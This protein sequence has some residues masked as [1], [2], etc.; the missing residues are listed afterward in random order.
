MG[1]E[2]R[3][4]RRRKVSKFENVKPGDTVYC[5][6]EEEDYS[7]FLFMAVCNGYVIV[8][9]EYSGLE[10]DFAGQLQEMCDE[11]MEESGIDV[12]LF[13]EDRVFLS[14]GEAEERL[15]QGV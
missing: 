10:N 6:G 5:I 11:S 12:Y 9:P 8:C 1:N 15:E 3:A 7:V 2:T 14:A 13:P 4:D